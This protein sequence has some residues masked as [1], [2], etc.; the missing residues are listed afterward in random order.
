MKRKLKKVTEPLQKTDHVQEANPIVPLEVALFLPII[1]TPASSSRAYWPLNG[2][3]F[4]EPTVVAPLPFF[5]HNIF[6]RQTWLLCYAKYT[7]PERLTLSQVGPLCTI[8][9]HL[10]YVLEGL[11]NPLFSNIQILPPPFRPPTHRR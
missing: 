7:T 6:L 9:S 4:I 11:Q 10:R 1:T 8:V 3:L 2:T 5:I